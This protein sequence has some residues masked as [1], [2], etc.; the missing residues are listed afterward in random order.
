MGN[1]LKSVFKSACLLSVGFIIGGYF[2]AMDAVRMA[3]EEPTEFDR[4]NEYI[5]S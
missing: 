2:I 3:K 4:L 5:K 1:F